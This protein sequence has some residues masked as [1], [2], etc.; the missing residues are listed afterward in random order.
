MRI[1]RANFYSVLVSQQFCEVMSTVTLETLYGMIIVV[2]KCLTANLISIQIALCHV[3]HTSYYKVPTFSTFAILLAD[4]KTGDR[5]TMRQIE[6][7]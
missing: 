6:I 2:S 7:M 4:P 5:N 3:A 1:L